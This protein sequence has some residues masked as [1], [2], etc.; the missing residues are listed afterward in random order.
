M[1][2]F[3]QSKH[4]KDSS[5]ILPVDNVSDVK[6]T[7]VG[8]NSSVHA[9]HTLTPEEVM[10]RRKGKTKNI[11]MEG[12]ISPLDQLKQKSMN[13]SQKVHKANNTAMPSDTAVP[14][15]TYSKS[16]F[17]DVDSAD[18]GSLLEK[19]MPFIKDAEAQQKPKQPD[20]KLESVEAILNSAKIETDELLKKLSALGTVTV[21]NLNKAKPNTAPVPTVPKH[22]EVTIKE[23]PEQAPEIIP[24]EKEEDLSATRVIPTISD[25]DN[26]SSTTQTI[27]Y[28]DISSGTKI[29]DLSAELFEAD[30]T[31]D[32]NLTDESESLSEKDYIVN[33]D[34][35]SFEDAQR[36]GGKLTK[37]KNG[38]RAKFIFTLLFAAVLGIFSIPAVFD[39]LKVSMDVFPTVITA[40]YTIICLINID[41]FISFRSLFKPRV[42]PKAGVGISAAITLIF[43]I[44]SV[45][46][47][48]AALYVV[49]F[50]SIIIC[51]KALSEYWRAKY[52]L[53]NFRVIANRNDKFAIQF[54]SDRQITFAMAKN[55]ISGD[56]L[57]GCPTPTQNI[58]DYVKNSGISVDFCG[59]FNSFLI[60]GFIGALITALII[61]IYQKDYSLLIG[62]FS[63]N[64]GIVFGPSLLF[65]D[66]LPLRRASSKLNR[67]GAMISG[68]NA[69]TLI[70]TANAITVTSKQ[71]FPAGAITLFNMKALDSNKIDATLLDAAAITQQIDSPL[72][73]LFENITK[74]QDIDLPKADSVKYEETLGISGWVDNRRIFIGNRTLLEA[75]GISVPPI[76]VDRKILQQGYFPLYVAC[77]DVPCALLI[78]QYNIKP[79]IAHELQKICNS[80]ITVLVDSCDPNM[81][82]EMICDYFGLP[83]ESVR[84][85]GSSGAQLYKAEVEPQENLSAVAAFK[86]TTESYLSIFNCAS[87]IKRC[88]K[89][90]TLLHIIL[91]FCMLAVNIYSTVYNGTDIILSGIAYLYVGIVTLCSFIYYLFNRP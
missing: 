41:M 50:S 51:F 26:A 71:L 31:T 72:Y 85:M 82:S 53:S 17:G 81:T 23:K 55:S 25:I 73:P 21:E 59:K 36:I 35:Q 84:V 65:T 80:G 89:A 45:I 91:S 42:E 5:N 46:N 34:Y 88:V 19:C 9:P 78:I 70:D 68:T 27:S 2:L 7:P 61:A 20:Y 69:A 29:I 28:Q 1:S 79:S 58:L 30:E 56:V 8:E 57:V 44:I 62:L 48:T 32:T 64:L 4:S 37:R 67:K 16:L 38:A 11:P 12:A 15:T 24:M 49:L 52:I 47:N 6:V 75:R 22:E 60:T 77:N 87:K 14:K 86:S 66:V 90:M 18:S 43:A 3:S 76:T 40:I 63:V 13:N 39:R 83:E 74:T 33:D 54:I 10:G